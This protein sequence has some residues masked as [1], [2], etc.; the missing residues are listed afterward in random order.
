M[1]HGRGGRPRVLHL[2]GAGTGA[3]EHLLYGKTTAARAGDA[4][5][6]IRE[7]HPDRVAEILVLK[8]ADGNPEY[9]AWV[10]REVDRK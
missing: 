9:I 1:R 7:T 5:R 3:R 6:R 10:A 2:A 4:V 8:I